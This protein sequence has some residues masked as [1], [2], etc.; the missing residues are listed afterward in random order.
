VVILSFVIN[1]GE[2]VYDNNQFALG[3]TVERVTIKSHNTG[4]FEF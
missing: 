2:N 1:F 4:N 3:L